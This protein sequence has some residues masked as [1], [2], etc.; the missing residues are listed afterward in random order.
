[1]FLHCLEN[2]FIFEVQYY[3]MLKVFIIDDHPSINL[4]IE[5]FGIGSKHCQ[6]SVKTTTG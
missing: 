4:A 5:F 2:Y 6:M 1:M 3:K